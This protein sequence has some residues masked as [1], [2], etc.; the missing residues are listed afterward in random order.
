MK[1]RLGYIGVEDTMIMVLGVIRKF[2]Q[3]H[4][5]PFL[6]SSFEEIP[7]LLREQT[8]KVDMW[9]FSGPLPYEVAKRQCDPGLPMYYIPFSGTSLY[10]ALCHILYQQNIDVSKISFDVVDERELKRLFSELGI[11]DRTVLCRS[12]DGS[13]QELVDFH[14]RLWTQGASSMAVTC[15]WSVQ[16]RL[17][18]LGVP[19][20]R[21]VPT[22]FSVESVL[23]TALREQ[24]TLLFMDTQVAVQFI[25]TAPYSG[26]PHST[27]SSDELY[28]ME[29]AVN[30]Q[31]LKYSKKVQGSLKMISPGRYVVFTTRGAVRDVTGNFSAVPDLQEIHAL[32]GQ[33]SGIGIGRTT[34]E[35]ELLAGKAL[36]HSKDY[37]QGTWMVYFEDKT[38]TG[39][40]GKPEQISF[41]YAS[42]SLKDISSRTSLSAATLGKLDSV[43]K[44][45]R[46]DQI[47]AH[48]LAR[49]MQIMPRSARRILIQLETGGFAQVVGEENPH[50]R[51]R[52]RKTYQIM[53]RQ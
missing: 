21:V 49:H 36:L 1:I 44:K 33:V 50:P 19:V 3:F 39:P 52:P 31:L 4:C 6:Y 45:L 43:L 34:Y 9:L 14:Y 8:P 12:Y 26:V 7:S 48:E 15:V 35:A 40:L 20:Y 24:E 29:M 25:E 10:R 38:V 2:P 30:Q 37:G 41:A 22:E 27:H 32:K 18:E 23:N 13:H 46:T 11:A 42:D 5:M 16:R 53:L 28:H 47:N 51:G 17:E